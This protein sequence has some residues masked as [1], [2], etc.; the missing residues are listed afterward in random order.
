MYETDE[1]G[2]RATVLNKDAFYAYLEEFESSPIREY[3]LIDLE[4]TVLE[5]F[6]CLVKCVE[7]SLRELPTMTVC[8][9][10]NENSGSTW[11]S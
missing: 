8:C 9:L 7:Q 5:G 2:T 10:V 4:V 3:G 6:K 11:M 1:A